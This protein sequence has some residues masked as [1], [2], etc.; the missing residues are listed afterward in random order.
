MQ[1]LVEESRDEASIDAGTDRSII[2]HCGGE[3]M[4]VEAIPV[5]TGYNALVPGKV[6]SAF[7][8]KMDPVSLLCFFKS[9][10][11]STTLFFVS[12]KSSNDA[13][14]RPIRACF[15]DLS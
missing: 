15:P 10:G 7:V 4:D 5:V 8:T 1:E 9:I 12:T 6:T 13:S 3:L 2:G 14:N 11:R